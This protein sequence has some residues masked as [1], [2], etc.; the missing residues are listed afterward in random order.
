MVPRTVAMESVLRALV[1]VAFGVLAPLLELF[2]EGLG[3]LGRARMVARAGVELDRA[4]QILH[5]RNQSAADAVPLGA[6]FHG[7][8]EVDEAAESIGA[9]GCIQPFGAAHA[10]A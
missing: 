6:L 3:L 9:A 7:P 1:H 4:G 5:Q 10:E 8:V 2:T